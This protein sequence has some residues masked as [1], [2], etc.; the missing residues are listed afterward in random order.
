[1]TARRKA[2]RNSSRSSGGDPKSSWSRATS[3]TSVVRYI[4]SANILDKKG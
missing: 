3:Q 4:K 2:E 1:M